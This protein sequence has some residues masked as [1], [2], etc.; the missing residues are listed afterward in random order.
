[1]FID[2]HTHIYTE[3]FDADCE[4]VLRRAIDAGAEALLLPAIDEHSLSKIHALCEAYPDICYPMIGIHPTDV[5]LDYDASLQRLEKMLKAKHSFV[6]IGEVGLDY[7]WD[8]S[9]KA[10]QK[11]VFAVQIQW[12]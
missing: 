4:E 11:E 2:T 5:P 7:Y 12:A 8:T 9:R 10:E 1:M 3:E 6:A